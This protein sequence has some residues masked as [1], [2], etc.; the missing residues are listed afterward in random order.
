M[1]VISDFEVMALLA[2]GMMNCQFVKVHWWE[3]KDSGEWE[4][5]HVRDGASGAVRF[6]IPRCVLS[7][8]NRV[9]V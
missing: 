5:V 6:Q 8:L 4:S 7:S 9:C 1:T 2:L 3:V